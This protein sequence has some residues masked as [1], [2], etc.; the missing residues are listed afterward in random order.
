MKFTADPR[1]KFV[2]VAVR[3]KAGPPVATM[4]GE[5]VESV[6]ITPVPDRGTSIFVAF[7]KVSS[8]VA[9]SR[10][11]VDGVN[12]MPREHCAKE[13]RENPAPNAHGVPVVGAP[14]TKSAEFAEGR[15]L[16]EVTLSGVAPL[17]PSSSV[18][19]ISLP[20]PFGT[21]P[22]S[23]GVGEHPEAKHMFRNVAGPFEV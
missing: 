18:P 20:M 15:M 21:D 17:L 22:K 8:S 10:A 6:G 16:I 5:I 11:T 13:A 7:E 2:P 4:E 23:T 12:V 19:S 1:T 9:V 14:R 3:V